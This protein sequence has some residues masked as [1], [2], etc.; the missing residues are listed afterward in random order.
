VAGAATEEQAIAALAR[1]ASI[2]MTWRHAGQLAAC[3]G[4]LAPGTRVFVSYL[5]GQ[6]WRES[7]ATCA[8]VQENGFEPVPHVP[9][10]LLIDR[11]ALARL[12]ADLVAQAGVREVL[13]IAG[14]AANAI[15]EFSST[16]DALR[17]GALAAQGIRSVF[18]A[19]HPEGHP[20]VPDVELRSAEQDKVEFAAV[21]GIELAFLSQFFFDP[22]P[23]LAWARQLRARGVRARLVAGLAGP[24]RLTT[25]FKYALRCGVGRSI[26]ALG[27]RPASFARLATE[28]GPEAIVRALARVSG[29]S[30]IEPLGI[31][32]FSFGGLARTSVWLRAVADG[33]FTLDD[34]GG[35]RVASRDA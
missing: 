8:A 21:H 19:G 2:E 1:A 10:R 12:A 24:A 25:L 11:E 20:S 33:A 13:L 27:A 35:F 9:A 28:R 18:V 22:A 17:S 30:A 26:R 16:L 7:V 34:A 6:T 5:P 14:D 29:G 4:L 3:R 31:H 23:F 32:L 15:G